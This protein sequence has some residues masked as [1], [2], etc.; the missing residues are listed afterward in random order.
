MSIF[1][2]VIR[3]LPAFTPY[4]SGVSDKVYDFVWCS[5]NLYSKN[6]TKMRF[7][8]HISQIF[9]TFAVDSYAGGKYVLR[10]AFRKGLSWVVFEYIE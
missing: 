10:K 6:R 8:L 7:F 4:T 9:C 2:N 3:V 1:S 5:Y